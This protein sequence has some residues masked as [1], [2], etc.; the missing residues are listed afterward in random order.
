MTTTL[1]LSLVGFVLAGDDPRLRRAPGAH[2]DRPS[3]S[4]V[5]SR[6]SDTIFGVY[7]GG[8]LDSYTCYNDGDGEITFELPV[9]RVLSRDGTGLDQIIQ[10][11]PT[12]RMRVYDVDESGNSCN[13]VDRVY[14]NDVLLDQALEGANDTWSEFAFDIP[15][16]AFSDGT[17]NSATFTKLGSEPSPGVNT[18]RVV[19][20]AGGC[21]GWCVE[22]D[23]AEIE[24]KAIRPLT[25]V[26][27]ILSDADAWTS[28]TEG[29]WSDAA[30]VPGQNAEA[31]DVGACNSTAE[32]AEQVSDQV[33][34]VLTSY[35]VNRTT[36][37]GHSKGGLDAEYA[38][39][40]APG[41]V[42][43]VVTI[44][45]PLQG[46]EAADH[47]A[48]DLAYFM[49]VSPRLTTLVLGAFGFAA[50]VTK[51]EGEILGLP[52]LLL[53]LH[54]SSR[55]SHYGTVTWRVPGA[56]YHRFAGNPYG[57]ADTTCPFHLFASDSEMFTGDNDGWVAVERAMPPW[58]T[59]DALDAIDH[60]VQT[61]TSTVFDWT[62]SQLTDSASWRQGLVGAAP[63]PSIGDTTVTAST[64]G[65]ELEA[66]DVVTSYVLVDGSVSSATFVSWTTSDDIEIELTAPD[67]S[68]WASGESSGHVTYAEREMVEG[69]LWASG[70][71][72]L[73]PEPGE[74]TVE[75][76]VGSNCE[77]G[78]L[79][80][81]ESDLTMSVSPSSGRALEGD[82][83]VI[84]A[85]L[86]EGGS[87]VAGADVTATLTEL[88][89]G[90]VETV[91]L[92]DSGGGAYAASW[93]AS[94]GTWTLTFAAEGEDASGY[95]FERTESALLEVVS[96]GAVIDSVTGDVGT[97]SDAD[98]L[99]DSLDVSVRLTVSDEGDYAVVAELADAGGEL[100]STAATRSTLATG[101]Q[102]VVLEF[103]GEAINEHRVD[104]PYSVSRLVLVD[105]ASGVVIDTLAKAYETDPYLWADFDGPPLVLRS[106]TDA[107]IDDD[108]DGAI[109]QIEIELEI[110]V[111]PGFEG[112]YDYNARIVDADG[113]TITWIKDDAY[114]LDA[115]ANALTLAVDTD[116]LVAGNHEAPYSVTS[117]YVYD[118]ATPDVRLSESNAYT[119]GNYCLCDFDAA[120]T[121]C[122]NPDDDA[123]GVAAC[124]GDCDDADPAVN[125]LATEA[126]NAIDDDCDAGID[127]DFDL[128][129]DGYT[130]CAGDCDD[131]D[132][133]TNPHGVE[134]CD[135]EDNDCDGDL[136]EGF[137]VDRDGVIECEG[138]CDD[139]DGSRSPLESETCNGV[140]DNCD[141][142]TDEGF[143]ADGDGYR[144][145]DDDCDD[146]DAN[147][148]PGGTESCN[149]HDDACDGEV[150]EAAKPTL[151][152]ASATTA[153][154][155]A[156][157]TMA[158]VA[159]GV[160][161]LARPSPASRQRCLPPWP[162]GGGGTPG[163]RGAG[164]PLARGPRTTSR[165]RLPPGVVQGDPVLLALG[166][167]GER[168]GGAPGAP[169]LDVGQPRDEA[170]GPAVD[171]HLG[172][173]DAPRRAVLPGGLHLHAAVGKQP[174]RGL[175]LQPG[176]DVDHAVLPSLA[177][178]EQHLLANGVDRH[179]EL[180]R[181]IE[182]EQP[183][184]ALVGTLLAHADGDA[185][186]REAAYPQAIHQ[187]QPGLALAV[188]GAQGDLGGR[189]RDA[190][191]DVAERVA[192]QR[193]D[194]GARVEQHRQFHVAELDRHRHAVAGA[195]VGQGHL[196]LGQRHVDRLAGRERTL[197]GG[198]GHL[199]V[200]PGRENRR[201]PGGVPRGLRATRGGEDGEAAGH[202]VVHLAG[203]IAG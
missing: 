29:T 152:A 191:P 92:T 74:W 176:A 199:A 165:R 159:A 122:T 113:S 169:R 180:S 68:T 12:L 181:D 63:P 197:G 162:P 54:T 133:F 110:E 31:Q 203:E 129:L 192:A 83:V 151:Q 145:C 66:G 30:W 137:D 38:S 14:L 61:E 44:G 67:G 168:Q 173:G 201:Q 187:H 161:P 198:W 144:T 95:T 53:S 98:G 45:S 51:C 93:T 135:G 81:F 186:D 128:D 99:Y 106:G 132:F 73:S 2:V 188:G 6:D 196:V 96:A 86:D 21:E 84:E 20:D 17:V 101:R 27:G 190:Q 18:I 8:E 58:D 69:E 75:L 7:D 107:G 136:D 170:L 24:V 141:G 70:F 62:W 126:C 104:G 172:L 202:G 26:H 102:S 153:A 39:V 11:Q 111:T 72:V 87:G 117:L 195:L 127:E 157:T 150:D 163:P 184:R 109:D 19:V 1:A 9:T 154:T 52:K 36:L 28:W 56:P 167:P 134:A 22:V 115:G 13:E 33:A 65:G 40:F 193:G 142:V 85:E 189:G 175:H 71:E 10:G 57:A 116:T 146:L 130:T 49:T 148:Y 200:V 47:I 37:V 43:N 147:V 103:D 105:A 91:T 88:E 80:E 155:R 149:G 60:T 112:E 177:G 119:T 32:N 34:D 108:G 171:A 23:Y 42:D 185:V 182:P 123:D 124:E 78:L 25:L 166:A 16:S 41:R 156:G 138:D 59:V 50:T 194:R 82:D 179:Q 120:P 48:S 35:G 158:A 5:S 89:S 94:R 174:R 139:R 114:A 125:P 3:L 140:D 76:S 143:N 15:V 90:T 121:G 77:Y 183:R 131:D 100:V 55:A 118:P 97:D 4:A 79:S 64:T 178:L 46:S 164:T 160:R